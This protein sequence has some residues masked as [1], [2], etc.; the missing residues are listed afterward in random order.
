S[1]KVIYYSAQ[2]FSVNRIKIIIS[3]G[4]SGTMYQAA[5]FALPAWFQDAGCNLLFSNAEIFIGGFD[6]T[7][8]SIS[9]CHRERLFV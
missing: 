5:V 1:L 8:S 4:L 7:D 6:P 2:L 9:E 3:K